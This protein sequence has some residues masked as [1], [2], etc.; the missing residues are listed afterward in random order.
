[1]EDFRCHIRSKE[2]GADYLF[3]TKD[4]ESILYPLRRQNKLVFPYTP[5]IQGGN[6]T[7]YED[8]GTPQSNYRYNAYTNSA[9]V[10][11]V[12]SGDFTAQTQEEAEYLLAVMHFFKGAGK[13]HFGEQSKY[14]GSPPVVMYFNYM[15]DYQYKDVPVVITSYSFNLQSDVDYIKVEKFNTMVPV[16]ITIMISLQ[17]NYNPLKV[18]KEFELGKF[19]EGKLLNKGYL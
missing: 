8:F 18:R 6:T 7:T 10:E 17:P 5:T 15:G 4:P 2:N 11:L 14:A 9:P 3:G 19:M 12:V 16:Y 13:M 1:M